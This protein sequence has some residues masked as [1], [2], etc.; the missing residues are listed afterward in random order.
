MKN[1]I[2]LASVGVATFALGLCLNNMALSAMNPNFNV[3]V[4]DVQKIVSSSSQVESLKVEQ[5]KQVEELV[6]FVEK[7]KS[8]LSKETDAKKKKELEDKY[9][10]ELVAKKDLIEKEY[11]KKLIAIDKNINEEIEKTAKANNYN[12]VL[13]KGVVL[14]GGTD[15]TAELQK[16]IK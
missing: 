4:V 8:E 9:N 15:I 6:S 10:K 5:K 7:A 13:A 2:K 16:T 11:T 1:K 3:A 14:Y 12:L